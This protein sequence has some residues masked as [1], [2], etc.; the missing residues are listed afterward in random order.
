M[1]GISKQKQIQ[2]LYL[3][4]G[5]GADYNTSSSALPINEHVDLLFEKAKAVN[6]L[7]LVDRSMLPKKDVKDLSKLKQAGLIL[8]AIKY[9]K[10]LNIVWLSQLTSTDAVLREKMTLFWHGHFACRI[11]NTVFVQ[12]LNNI[13]RQYALGK[14]KDLLMAVSKSPAMLEFLNNKQNKKQHPNENFARELME[15]FTIGRSNY[16]EQDI[17]ESA[18]AFTG[19]SFDQQGNF[20]I[21]EKQH[22]EG[23]KTF[24][25]KT[26]NFGGEDVI[27]ILLQR[28]ETAH[29]ICKKIYRFFVN[30]ELDD[31]IVNQLTDS[32]YNSDYDIG[33]L[34]KTIFTA[35]WFY[36]QKNIGTKIK[37]PVELLV[38]LNRSFGVK[39][40][41]PNV[42]LYIQKV[43]GQVLFFPPNVSGWSGGK[44]WIDSSSLMIRLKLPSIVLN[45]GIIEAEEKDEP[46]DYKMIAERKVVQS[47]IQRKVKAIASWDKF[48]A[49]LPKEI[50]K[51]KL[52]NYLLQVEPLKKVGNM[53]NE[54]NADDLKTTTVE[55]LSLPEYQ[56]C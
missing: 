3:R 24:M 13:E 27:D 33:A 40:D 37:S 46:E 31:R 36:D 41:D 12:E 6:P 18:R 56:M 52:M 35:D 45:G 1:A 49:A 53:I 55:I 10:E 25:G 32:F 50:T 14:F 11:I 17:K 15:L 4:A 26:G 9:N 34:M 29:F 51:E 21:R 44:N 16:T 23:E 28:K 30:D 54:V 47:K 19:W 39:Y 7:Q 22:D 20:E 43:L 5:F 38:G 42:L 8:K 48:S 2:H